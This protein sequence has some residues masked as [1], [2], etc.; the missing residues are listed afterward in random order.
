[1]S[2]YNVAV[3]GCGAIFGR[4]LA[5]LRANPESYN[6]IGFFDI[7]PHKRQE[8]QAS[9][10]D[11]KAYA[12]EDEV[13]ADEEVDYIVI[14]TPSY[15]HFSQA[16]RALN[17]FKHVLLEKPASFHPDQIVALAS[18][19]AQQQRQV[20]CVLQVRLNQSITIVKRILAEG[21]IGKIHGSALVQRWQRPLS[22]FSGWR[23][24]YKT[25]GGVL[26]EFGIHYLDIMQYLLGLPTVVAASFYKNKFKDT[27]VSDTAYALLDFG[28]FGASIE[29][30][31]AAEPHNIE[32]SLM[33]MG[34]MGY[35]KLGGKS[36]DQI[37][38]A[39][40]LTPNHQLRYRT[41]CQEVLGVAIDS[42]VTIGACPHHPELYKQISSHP[43]LFS[44]NNTYN[45]IKL[46]NDINNLDM[47]AS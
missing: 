23:G 41:I 40:F 46:V 39:E 18:L 35:I 33:I 29:V 14:L 22:Y 36:L 37:I 13:Y 32:V 3:L 19:A 4:H 42:Q 1:M 38:A 7:D 8:W 17:N 28:S 34:S 21:L 45:V 12:T 24:S 20:F 25:C 27:P 6:F 47:L 44:L 16:C 30:S 31:L 9:L 43:E 26:H 2:K 15:L 11:V 10:P 5:A